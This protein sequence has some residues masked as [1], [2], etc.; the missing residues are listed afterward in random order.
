MRTPQA[1]RRRGAGRAVLN[2]IV[3]EARRRG[4]R[5]AIVPIVWADRRGSRMHARP[6]LALRVAWDGTSIAEARRN[7]RI[8]SIAVPAAAG[9]AFPDIPPPAGVNLKALK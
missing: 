9:A 6:G 3:D 2:R 5:I 7:A 8:L 1:H 4:Y